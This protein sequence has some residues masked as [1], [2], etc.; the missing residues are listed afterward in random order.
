M[1]SLRVY[2]LI[3]INYKEI[4]CKNIACKLN[5]YIIYFLS[6]HKTVLL[7]L[8]PES[9]FVFFQSV[10]QLLMPVLVAETSCGYFRVLFL[11]KGINGIQ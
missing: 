5:Q 10:I 8:V 7:V 9:F 2:I 6:N 11:A 4:L 1:Q 3:F